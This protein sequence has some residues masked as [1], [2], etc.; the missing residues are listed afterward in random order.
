MA[1]GKEGTISPAEQLLWADQVRALIPFFRE[2]EPPADQAVPGEKW[3][4]V[5]PPGC[6]QEQYHIALMVETEQ[7]LRKINRSSQSN[8]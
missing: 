4:V 5:I 8:L 6:R 1:W 7:L 2:K 3:T